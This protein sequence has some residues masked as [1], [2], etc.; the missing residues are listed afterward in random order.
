MARVTVEDCLE[1][2][3]NRFEL[4]M[5]ASKRARQLAT[6]G[7]EPKVAWENDK[8]TVVA[9]REVA[10]GLVSN[11]IL[12]EEALQDQQEPLYS[13]ETTELAE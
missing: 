2:V 11:E 8:P 7:K 10:E 5:L 9:L 13:L 4:V 6:G 3:D 12:A 1:N